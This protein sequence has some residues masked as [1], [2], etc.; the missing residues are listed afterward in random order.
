MDVIVRLCV[1]EDPDGAVVVDA[2]SRL[3]EPRLSGNLSESAIGESGAEQPT[4]GVH[5]MKPQKIQRGE[6]H[7]AE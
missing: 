4:V 2:Q 3:S 5:W 6:A 7:G 1:Q